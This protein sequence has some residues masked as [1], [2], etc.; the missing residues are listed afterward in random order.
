M[1][2]VACAEQK[3]VLKRSGD[4]GGARVAAVRECVCVW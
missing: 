1:R 3:R 4:G 2:G